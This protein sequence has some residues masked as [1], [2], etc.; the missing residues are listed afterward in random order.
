[1]LDS[2]TAV[3]VVAQQQPRLVILDIQMP[4][5]DGW[6]VLAQLRSNPT[7]SA[8]PV[9]ICSIID[10]HNLSIALGAHA[11]LVKPIREEELLAVLRRMAPLSTSV[12]LIDDD[13][14]ARAVVRA[15]LDTTHY[16]VVEAASG[17]AALSLVRHH[18][19]GLI[20]LD[21]ML[22]DIDGFTILDLL[23]TDSSL[24]AVPIIVLSAKE[25]T[26]AELQWLQERTQHV[27]AKT[28]FSA[29]DFIHYVKQLTR[30]E[31]PHE[32]ST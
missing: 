14:D 26:S 5:V 2:R 21:L 8:I 1:V 31:T 18:P 24:A 11:H 19:P 22:P 16:T 15:I 3:A 7:T 12:M 30:K 9:V 20:I 13:D 23:R 27:L 17:Q 10:Q 28:K 6:E 32:C 29:E 25:L 4:D